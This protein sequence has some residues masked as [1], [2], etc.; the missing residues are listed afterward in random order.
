MQRKSRRTRRW[1]ATHRTAHEVNR[2][3]L[4]VLAAETLTRSTPK[5][6]R[7]RSPNFVA[8][9]ANNAAPAQNSRPSP[10][11]DRWIEPKDVVVDQ[12]GPLSTRR[13]R[14]PGARALQRRVVAAALAAT[15]P[16]AQRCGHLRYR[17]PTGLRVG[18]SL[19]SAVPA[20]HD[21]VDWT[22]VG[23]TSP[24]CTATVQHVLDTTGW[25]RC[26]VRVVRRGGPRM[27]VDRPYRSPPLVSS[28]PMRSREG[29]G[30]WAW[31]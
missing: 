11:P 15:R 4:T 1:S 17:V 16:R 29:V 30:A 12:H 27:G 2:H 18:E 19:A 8:R 28:R 23:P 25:L 20:P 31:T 13:R 6:P 5:H 7:L 9:V 22:Q 24:A 3:H 14:A 26:D 10:R 21:L